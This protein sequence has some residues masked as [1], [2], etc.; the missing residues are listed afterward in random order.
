MERRVRGLLGLPLP[1]KRCGDGK[2][3]GGTNWYKPASEHARPVQGLSQGA[4]MLVRNR[5]GPTSTFRGGSVALRN[6]TRLR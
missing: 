1:C 4:T 3:T 5:L 2:V 6:L